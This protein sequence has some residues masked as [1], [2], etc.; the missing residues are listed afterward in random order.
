MLF[1]RLSRDQ[2]EALGNLRDLD[3]SYEVKAAD[4]RFRANVFQ[5]STGLGAVFRLV[6][7]EVP[8][9]DE[10]GLPPIVAAK[11]AYRHGL[12]L[13][14][15]PTGSGKSTTLAA[16][17]ADINQR[18]GAHILTFEDPIEVVHQRRASLINQREIGTH[19]RVLGRALRAALREDPDVI[20]MGEMRDV[21]TLAFAITA[22][23]TGHLVFATVH[24]V[25]ADTSIDRMIN[26][27]PAGQQSQV[28]TILAD[29]LRAVVCQHLL[30]R[31]D[32]PGRIAA[33]EVLLNT[34]AVANLIRK[35][36]T[37]Q[38]PSV[39][40]TAR[41]SGMQSM[42][43]ELMRLLREGRIHADEA[44]MKAVDK[45]LFEASLPPEQRG[46]SAKD[47]A[48]NAAPSA[49]QNA[50]AAGSPRGMPPRGT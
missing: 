14:G 3:F 28:R 45:K 43:S 47:R 10:L 46:E 39:I 38:I 4:L 25:S 30:R 21:E 41:E 40:A 17:I 35:G 24:T 42:D 20:L 22:A 1:A 5:Q 27:F 13:V 7:N 16:L 18:T 2:I 23:E 31:A 6:R 19:V 8:S 9:L 34:D 12:V 33:V 15:G 48:P 49:P 26:A 50:G 36:K 11:G 37:F 29:A 44:Y 32:G